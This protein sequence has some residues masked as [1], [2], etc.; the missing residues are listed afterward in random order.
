VS[1]T[2]ELSIEDDGKGFDSVGS[3]NAGAGG[4]GLQSMQERAEFSG[5]TYDMESA[6]GKGTR[7][8]VRW[9]HAGG[10]KHEI[11]LIR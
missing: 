4:L 5:G 11:A 7:I 3:G 1:D 2:I 8:C 9:P 6:P 10:Q